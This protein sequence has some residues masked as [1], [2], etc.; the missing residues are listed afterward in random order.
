[1][2]GLFFVSSKTK[3][4]SVYSSNTNTSISAIDKKNELLLETMVERDIE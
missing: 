4:N 1:M 3:I 2:L